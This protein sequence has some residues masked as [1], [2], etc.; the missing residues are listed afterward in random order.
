MLL[1]FNDINLSDTNKP[2]TS[3]ETSQNLKLS[4]SSPPK[5]VENF[6]TFQKK[7][8]SSLVK[9]RILQNI[10]KHLKL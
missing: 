9:E 10:T 7:Q 6:F 3:S 2:R 4:E 8:N 1:M 5:I